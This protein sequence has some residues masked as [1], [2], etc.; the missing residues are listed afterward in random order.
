MDEDFPDAL[1]I[2]VTNR[3]NFNCLM[4]IRHVWNAKLSD[5]DIDLYKGIAE[6]D[7]SR[8]NKLVLYGIGEP[9]FNPHFLDILRISRT[10]LPKESEILIS[11]NGSLL[12]PKVAEKI[13]KDIGVDSISFSIDTMD[14]AKLENIRRNSKPRTIM[15]NL[16]YIAK[17]KKESRRTFKLGV[18]AVVMK[19]NFRDIPQLVKNLAE[20]D[21]D[22]ILI[23]HVVPYTETILKE[24]AYTTLIRPPF[25]V[26]RFFSNYRWNSMNRVV[27]RSDYRTDIKASEVIEKFREKIEENGYQI[28]RAL[29]FSFEEKIEMISKVRE[30]FHKS[31]KIANE[32]QIDLK[33]PRLYPDAEKRNCPYVDKNM[34]FIRSDGKVVP[35]LE[36]AYSHPM[37]VNT[38]LKKINEIIFGDLKREKLKHIWN[39]E[40][41]VKFRE[42]RENLAEN[43]PWCG[44]CPYSTMGCFYTETNEFD[45]Y[46]NKPGCNE[47]LYSVGLAQCNI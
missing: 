4:C 17:I 40:K 32:Y 27:H 45:C 20:R 5:L 15:E 11:T 7:F 31:E 18:E 39:R 47:C 2:E 10:H 3:C 26:I 21:V 30:Y 36:F 34:A 19:E 37:Y 16:Q 24:T 12:T 43:I 9:F 23:S 25:E 42:I 22:Y 38:H 1:Q 46:S 13:L 6:S 41:Y 14:I 29:I 8:L 44:E 35:C 33:L 28:D